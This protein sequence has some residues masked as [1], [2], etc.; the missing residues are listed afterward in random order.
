MPPCEHIAHRHFLNPILLC[1]QPL[2]IPCQC[3]GI[4][5]HIHNPLRFHF[6][7]G[8][9][10]RLVAALSRRVYHNY[11]C[12]DALYPYLRGSTSSA[13]PTENS[14]FLIPFLSAFCF[15]SS[16][17]AGT[18]STHRPALPSVPEKENSPD[19]RSKRSDTGSCPVRPA[20]SRALPYSFSSRRIHLV[21]GQRRNPIL[22]FPYK[23]QNN[24][25]PKVL[26]LCRPKLHYFSSY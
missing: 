22:Y 24:S 20:Y 23:I 25:V 5:A 10:Q 18:I 7:H 14:V 16:M 12:A 2:Q 26:P 17:A 8:G 13:F 21:K 3:S 9:K 19:L 11:I 4:T 6:Q 1:A 15:A